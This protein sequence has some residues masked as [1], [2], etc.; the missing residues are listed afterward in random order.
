MNA[1]PTRKNPNNM[2]RTEDGGI[3]ISCDYCGTDWDE[4]LPMI[5]GHRGSVLCLECLKCALDNARP[6]DD[7]IDCA[8]CLSAS[9][10]G[11]KHWRHPDPKPSDGLNPDAILCWDCIRLAA[12]GYHKDPDIDFRWDSSKYPKQVDL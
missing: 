9:P 6:A 12:K 2:Q 7:T 10:A 11:T 4:Q 5:E 1:N 3:V 8:L